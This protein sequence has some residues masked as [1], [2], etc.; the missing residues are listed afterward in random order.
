MVKALVLAV[1]AS[2]LAIPAPAAANVD[3]TRGVTFDISAWGVPV[4]RSQQAREADLQVS[5]VG[6]DPQ[7]YAVCQIGGARA[8]NGLLTQVDV[9]CAADRSE[10]IAVTL[11][12]PA[13]SATLTFG[14]VQPAPVGRASDYNLSRYAGRQMRY[15]PCR[16]VPVR[17]NPGPSPR[18]AFVQRGFRYALQQVAQASGIQLRYKG[19]T[20]FV[21][22]NDRRTKGKGISVAYVP[23]S[24]STFP[25][26]R[27]AQV[28]GIGGW[29]TDNSRRW[30]ASGYAVIKRSNDTEDEMTYI[31]TVM[32]E[33]G[34][35]VGLDHASIRSKQVMAPAE[36]APGITWG[37]GDLRGLHK[38]GPRT[39]C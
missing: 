3:P 10:A 31:L 27:P 9:T 24:R 39:S 28:L 2:L 15:K 11:R 36:S 26:L 8:S 37:K 1:A 33:I 7:G 32:H 16:V 12:G 29:V 14:Y 20:S 25:Q 30:L 21:P 22:G 13:Q 5:A 18:P 6:S 17:F 35:A 4:P 34:H 19:H 23:K 38:A